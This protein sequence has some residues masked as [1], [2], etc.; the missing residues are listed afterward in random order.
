MNLETVFLNGSTY[1]EY[2]LG[3]EVES[4]M[5]TQNKHMQPGQHVMVFLDDVAVT[6]PLPVPADKETEN[7]G[8][9]GLVLKVDN[10]TDLKKGDTE[11]HLKIKKL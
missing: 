1:K 7:I 9:E 4:I 3:A 5:T 8:V 11:Q 6:A 2:L 10:V